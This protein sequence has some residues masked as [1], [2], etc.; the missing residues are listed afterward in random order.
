MNIP[1]KAPSD[2]SDLFREPGDADA[3]Q[4]DLFEF[5]SAPQPEAVGRP[6]ASDVAPA[7]APDASVAA[8]GESFTWHNEI[9][10][11]TLSRVDV[12]H[13]ETPPCND[14]AAGVRCERATDPAVAALGEVSTANLRRL[15]RTLSWLQNEVEAC[16]LPRAAPLPPVPGLPAIEPVIDR[17]RIDRKL[18][19][20]PTLPIWLQEQQTRPQPPPLRERGVLWPRAVKLLIACGVAA[21]LS[22]YFAVATS[23][24]HEHAIEVAAVAPQAALVVSGRPAQIL[25]ET[26]DGVGMAGAESTSAQQGALAP[27]PMVLPLASPRSPPATTGVAEDRSFPPPP[28]RDSVSATKTTDLQEVKLL[29]ERGKQFF[30]AGDFVAAR[31]LFLR[32]A[33][34]GDGAAAV[35][36]GATYD[37][38]VLADRGVLGVAADLAKAR[39]WYERA[40]EMGSPEGPRRLE[41]LANR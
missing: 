38:I 26:P 29:I 19:Q 27:E 18:Q 1:L 2:Q 32:A 23:P 11:D 34:A 7:A 31:I 40:K 9:R 13:D 36:M 15:E 37:P 35:A 5:F 16:R 6:L 17:R 12:V 3:A 39:S 24:L 30:E 10:Q 20:P 41:M 21:P 22:Y 8:G 33:N 4:R 14:I 25:P 28:E